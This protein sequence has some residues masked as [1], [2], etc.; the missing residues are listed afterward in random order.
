MNIKRGVLLIFLSFLFAVKISA[1]SYPEK[2]SKEALISIVNI[3]YKNDK[4]IFSK[5]ALRFYDKNTDFDEVVDFSY[6]DNFEDSFFFIKFYF[7]GSRAKIISVPFLDFAEKESD[8]NNASISEIILNLT[9][10]EISYIF[11]FLKNLHENLPDYDY[12]F[13]LEKNNSFTHISAILNDTSNYFPQLTN[14]SSFFSYS[15]NLSKNLK[16]QQKSIPLEF[17]SSQEN[18][19]DSNSRE[20]SAILPTVSFY[21]ILFFIILSSIFIF[22]TTY[23]LLV[24]LTK[25]FY[26]FSIFRLIQT[27]DF[28][29]FF[30]S[31]ILGIIILFQDFISNQSIFRNNFKFLYLFPLNAVMAFNVYFPFI[32]N[33][34]SKIYWILVSSLDVMYIFL[35]WIFSKEFPIIDFLI[36]IPL[37]IRSVYFEMVLF[38]SKKNP[39]QKPDFR[40]QF[41]LLINF[42]LS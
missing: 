25:K 37:F 32:K 31:G 41:L 3:D 23:Q 40:N 26:I 29:L 12:D 9:Y 24:L 22:I 4:S 28:L 38:L 11:D 19:Y 14:N 30:L 8:I 35:S 36:D 42:L 10:L 20:N 2:L 33:K 6:F 1:S 21:K 16:F 39:V 17:F 15:R 34:F 13:D 18:Y 5:S 27:I 7:F